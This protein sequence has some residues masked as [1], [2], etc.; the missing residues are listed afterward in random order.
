MKRGFTTIDI[1]IYLTFMAVVFQ[2]S[3]PSYEKVMRRVKA[4]SY[5]QA[6]KVA[7]IKVEE[8]FFFHN[9]LPEEF[10][11]SHDNKIDISFDSPSLSVWSNDGSFE[12]S[13]NATFQEDYISWECLGTEPNEISE[14]ICHAVTS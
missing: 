2:V 14:F 6:I 7:Q 11:Y 4:Q 12:L 9:R 5:I 8:T 13:L 3:K 1:L 10:S